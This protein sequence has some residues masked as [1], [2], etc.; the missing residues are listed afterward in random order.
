MTAQALKLD[1]QA[2]LSASTGVIGVALPME[3]I[4]PAIASL[5][6]SLHNGHCDDA[7]EAILTTDT[8]P[9]QF[10]VEFDLSGGVKARI[11]AI[12]KGSGMIAPNMATM[13]GFITTDVSIEPSVLQEM[14]TRCV[15]YTFNSITVDGDTSTNDMVLALANGAAENK[16]IDSPQSTDA[17]TFETASL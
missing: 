3:K 13:L 11:G 14:L 5:V 16:I 7:A 10:A 17:A 12:A 1:R 2:V 9:K 6:S 15:W 8:F 4:T